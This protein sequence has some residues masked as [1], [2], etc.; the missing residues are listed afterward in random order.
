MFEKLVLNVKLIHVEF[1]V[2]FFSL[3]CSAFLLCL[4]STSNDLSSV[5]IRFCL[6]FFLLYIFVHIF[7]GIY[8]LL[9]F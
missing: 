7:F 1:S 2:E 4:F 6:N 9:N 3:F 5:F 8:L